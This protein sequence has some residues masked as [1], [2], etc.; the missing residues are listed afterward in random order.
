M[1]QYITSLMFG[2]FLLCSCSRGE[3]SPIKPEPPKPVIP[4]PRP[5]PQRPLSGYEGYMIIADGGL[6]HIPI[7]IPSGVLTRPRLW[8]MDREGNIKDDV[9]KHLI[10]QDPD[11]DLVCETQLVASS[12]YISLLAR[13]DFLA[14]GHQHRSRLILIDRKTLKLTSS[15]QIA[16]P[17]SWSNEWVRKS[18]VLSDGTAYLA[19]TQKHFYRLDA[20]SGLYTKL[21]GL[22]PRFVTSAAAYEDKGFFTL[23]DDTHLYLF[24]AGHTK[25][26]RLSLQAHGG[27]TVVASVG[28]YCL[29]QDHDSR[30][31]L[32]SLIE[33]KAL[34]T[35][36]LSAP[37]GRSIYYD[38][39]QGHLYYTGIGNSDAQKRSLYRVS[40]AQGVEQEQ[41]LHS[42]LYYRIAGR[43]EV[44]SRQGYFLS[45]GYNPTTDKLYLSW[46][47]QG[48][49][50]PA[51]ENRT[52]LVALP[53]EKSAEKLPVTQTRTY[54]LRQTYDVNNILYLSQVD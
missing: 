7:N 25:A 10:E 3:D 34:A 8:L 5:K 2:V 29:L 44:D 49:T 51:V 54:E 27:I 24:R 31:F 17:E 40:L 19:F 47:D 50:G 28:Q 41:N 43:T 23:E 33:G 15:L 37:A 22:P 20:K 38:A 45:L 30:Y 48:R 32:F 42:V 1:S 39:E 18:F 21:E 52:K 9:Y 4:Q 35:F 14:K 13:Y 36:R 16:Q 26:E 53:L 11:L 6:S 46:L 12:R